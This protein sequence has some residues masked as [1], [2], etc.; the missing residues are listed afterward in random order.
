MA[1]GK[2]TRME[3]NQEKLL[4]R[5]KKPIILHVI[6][7]LK[8]SECFSK[9]IAILSPN[10]PKTKELLEHNDVNIIDTH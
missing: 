7:A 6:D 4:L 3:S 5:H 2:G 10:V 1:G 9:L 8:D